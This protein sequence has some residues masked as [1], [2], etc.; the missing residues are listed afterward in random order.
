MQ[1]LGLVAV[2]CKILVE[3]YQKALWIPPF[4]LKIR[5]DPGT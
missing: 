2:T 1:T 5:S 4:I 3:P